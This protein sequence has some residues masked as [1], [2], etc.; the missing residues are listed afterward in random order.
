MQGGGHVELLLRGMEG[1]P[2]SKKAATSGVAAFS[3]NVADLS[4]QRRRRTWRDP[5]SSRA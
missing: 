5:S 1:R 4:I 2:K 3:K